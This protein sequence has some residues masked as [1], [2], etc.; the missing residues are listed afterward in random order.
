[1]AVN[2]FWIDLDT[3]PVKD[4]D[5]NLTFGNL[6]DS[7]TRLKFLRRSCPDGLL[8]QVFQPPDNGSKAVRLAVQTGA[9]GGPG[10]LD[11]PKDAVNDRCEL[12]QNPKG[13]LGDD[14]WYGFSVRVPDEF[15][16]RP[17]R[18]VIAQVKMPFDDLGNGSPAFS[19]RI[20]DRQ[21]LATVE[22]LYEEEDEEDHRF[23]STMVG[24]A[25]GLPGTAAYDHHDFTQDEDRLDRQIRALLANDAAGPPPHLYQ[26]EFTRCTTGVKLAT[27]GRL[28]EADGRWSDF[29][30]RV[31]SSGVKNVDGSIELYCEQELIAEASGEFGFPSPKIQPPPQYFKIGPY[32]NNDPLWGDEVATIEVRDIR[33]GPS[34]ESVR[35]SARPAPHLPKT[36]AENPARAVAVTEAGG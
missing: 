20:D 19:L 21:W 10:K 11:D 31:K 28:P 15:P 29:I 2:S 33:K 27:F 17:L 13:V 24:G 35:L 36:A 26:Y 1:M 14:A 25:C 4:G 30:V 6:K 16:R 9:Y 7:S 8:P 23:V 12:R 3:D 22:H 18:C 32:R 34:F 5:D